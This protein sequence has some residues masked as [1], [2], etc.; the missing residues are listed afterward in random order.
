MVL[1]RLFTRGRS[2]IVVVTALILH[3]LFWDTT[4][5]TGEGE[6]GLL[7]IITADT[8]GTDRIEHGAELTSKISPS[9][10]NLG[11]AVT[12]AMEQKVLVVTF[13]FGEKTARKRSFRMFVE[14]TRRSGVDFAIVGHPAPDFPLPPNVRHVNVTWNDLTDRVKERV[15]KGQE[16]GKMRSLTNY[17]K[18]ND[19]KPLFAH[20]FP[21][22]L[23]GFD[24]WG[25][26]DSD[27]VVGNLRH[28]LTHEMLSQHDI[29][30]GVGSQYT[31]GPLMF[32][33]N[34]PVI[35]DLFRK[36][37]R[38]LMEVFGVERCRSFDEY[39]GIFYGLPRGY[40]PGWND[41]RSSMGGIVEFF[42]KELGLRW[43][44]GLPMVWDGFCRGYLFGGVCRE[45]QL[46]QQPGGDQKLV[47]CTLRKNSRHCR[48]DSEISICHYQYSK[49]TVE[50]SLGNKTQMEEFIRSGQ[51]RLNFFDGFNMLNSTPRTFLTGTEMLQIS[52]FET[53]AP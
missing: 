3:I 32:Y 44:G 53:S 31:V 38:P 18:I 17:Y 1:Q 4:L 46:I 15:F 19:F 47:P 43:Y 27:V 25:Y 28:F 10:P 49:E 21:D 16:P 20:L 14:S 30:G 33:R 37:R 50:E 51:F 48:E 22:E 39:G 11:A 6:L 12:Q 7:S 9:E 2:I 52:P 45:C 41:Y 26:C 35:N 40:D 13:L 34:S 5:L 36:S 23:K 8:P 42:H 29:I 24:W